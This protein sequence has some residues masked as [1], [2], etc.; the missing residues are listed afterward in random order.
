MVK[1]SAL[2]HLRSKG[3]NTPVPHSTVQIAQNRN[4]KLSHVNVLLTEALWIFVHHVGQVSLSDV[5]L[6]HLLLDELRADL[7]SSCG[8][9]V[10]PAGCRAQTYPPVENLE[11]QPGP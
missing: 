6:L 3:E 4:E 10:L 11:E 5:K 9:H 1:L 7:L 8:R 2:K